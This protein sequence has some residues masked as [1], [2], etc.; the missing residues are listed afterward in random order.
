[1]I[2]GGSKTIG[3]RNH[4]ES[5]SELDEYFADL[6]D[7]PTE[8]DVRSHQPEVSDT[9]NTQEEL[10]RLTAH[11][12]HLKRNISELADSPR[13]LSEPAPP[14]SNYAAITAGFASVL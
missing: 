2:Q 3:N 12:S 9:G 5:R 11:V 13:T 10:R 14:R 8:R 1:M 7:E 6:N 4:A